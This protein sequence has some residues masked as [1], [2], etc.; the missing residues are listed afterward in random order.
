MG[1]SPDIELGKSFIGEGDV[2]EGIRA[3]SNEGKVGE[4]WIGLRVNCLGGSAGSVEQKSG[5]GELLWGGTRCGDEVGGSPPNG[6][7][8]LPNE[9]AIVS[10]VMH[11]VR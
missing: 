5:A 4:G 9:N 7:L 1:V 6:L 2:D 10:W 11:G 3:L 8:G